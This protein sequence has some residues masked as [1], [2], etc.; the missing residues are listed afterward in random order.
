MLKFITIL[1]ELDSITNL[2]ELKNEYEKIKS[3]LD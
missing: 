3:I 1:N 2:A